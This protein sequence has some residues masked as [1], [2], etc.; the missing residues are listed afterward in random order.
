MCTYKG[1]SKIDARFESEFLLSGYLKLTI[2][3][4]NDGKTIRV[5]KEDIYGCINAIQLHL[6]KVVMESFD[7]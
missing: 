5:L 7:K 4:V 6:S 2:Y 3:F 1:C